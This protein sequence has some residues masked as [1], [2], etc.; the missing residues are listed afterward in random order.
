VN[1]LQ[2]TSV[3]LS[4]PMDRVVDFEKDAVVWRNDLKP[5][6]FSMGVGVLDPCDKATLI[7]VESEDIRKE[8]KL[9]KVQGRYDELREIMKPICAVDARMVDLANFLILYID[10][11]VHMMGSY[12]EAAIAISQ[13]KPVLV[14]C[15][16]GKQN[17]PDWAFGSIPH[18]MMFS[19][20]GEVKEYLTHIDT[21]DKVEHLR[22]WWFFDIDHIFG[23][24]T[25]FSQT[26]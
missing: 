10:I 8:K 26:S 3:Y 6:L 7:G 18:E 12:H 25:K 22:R 5:F 15:K 1:R 13:K 19:S 21:A 17:I 2:Q 16:Q 4:G 14:M 23:R 9:L 24:P 11:D 20:W